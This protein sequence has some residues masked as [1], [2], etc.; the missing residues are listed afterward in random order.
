MKNSFLFRTR[1]AG[2]ALLC[3]ATMQANDNLS[4]PPK[5]PPATAYASSPR[6]SEYVEK[7]DT[8]IVTGTVDRKTTFDLAQGASLLSGRALKLQ[9]Q[10]SL[11]ETLANTPGVNSTYYGPGSSR[12]IIRGLG[13]DRVRMLQDSVGSLDLSNI[14]PD[15]NVSIEPLLVDRI[16]VLRG[17]ATLLYGSSAVGGVVNVIDNR[18]PTEVRTK[19]IG[20]RAEARLDTAA[21][22]RTG[23]VALSGGSSTFGFQI[24]GQR[25]VTDEVR[26]PG[27]AQ[28]GP[29]A[30]E[31]QPEG[32]LPS[33]AVSTKTA[34]VGGTAF[35]KTGFL[36]LAAS[37][38]D[39]TYGVPTGDDPPTSIDMRQQRL[40]LRGVLTRGFGPF[41][42]LR[43]R[44]G[45]GNYTHRELSGGETVNTTFRNKATEGRIELVQETK[46]RLAGTI[47]LQASRADFSASGEEVVTPATLTNAAALFALEEYKLE[48]VTFQVGSR[49]EWQKIKLGEVHEDLP[50]FT[51]YNAQSGEQ[52]TVRGF[53]LSTG[54]VFYPL[55]DYSVGLSVASSQRLPVAQELYSNG[56]HGGTAAYEVG[57]STLGK[58]KS[59]GFDLTLRRRASRVTGSVGLFMN[60][61]THY[62]FEQELP[63]DLKPATNNPDDLTPYQFVSTNALFYGGEAEL[64]FH[65]IDENER[66][67]HLELSSDYVH[68]EQTATNQPLPRIPPMRTGAEL[69]FEQHGWAFGASCKYVFRQNRCSKYETATAGYCLLGLD[70]G[71][72]FELD[73]FKYDIFLRGSNLTNREARVHTSFL[74]DYAP[75]PAR[76]LT[77]GIRASF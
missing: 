36:G 72:E 19:T 4:P 10:P 74:K 35:V 22:E 2:T 34:S 59:L 27:F 71:Y 65:L 7:L 58:E 12:P 52:R 70:A 76:N 8:V 38:Y 6:D 69:R 32:R 31:N 1:T 77:L 30:P 60:K 50:E 20:G 9:V 63:E 33:S 68:A 39:T 42:E 45:Y 15:H 61:F 64:E 41:K 51:G 73:G 26:I 49:Y 53:S 23:I 46:D 17:P 66:S 48:R 18:I 29:D 40:D 37:E 54:A 5:D 62:I 67:L 55:K 28:K 24:D 21:K 11:G 13:G 47:G 44:G 25:T 3:A 75:L 16:E 56:P 14:S 57:N 43:V